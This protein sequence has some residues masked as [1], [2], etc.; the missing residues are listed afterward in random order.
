MK[1]SQVI[2]EIENLERTL[3]RIKV[4]SSKTDDVIKA[5]EEAEVMLGIFDSI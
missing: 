1:L 2:F 5:Q 4:R 3:I